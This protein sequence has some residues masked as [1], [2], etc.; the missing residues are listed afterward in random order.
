LR[1]RI[2]GTGNAAQ[3]VVRNPFSCFFCHLLK[4]VAPWADEVHD[5][6]YGVGSFYQHCPHIRIHAADIKRWPWIVAPATFREVDALTYLRELPTENRQRR[7]VVVDPPYPTHPAGNSHRYEWLYYPRPWP[8]AYLTAVLQEARAKARAV[9]L[10]Y[11]GDRR[12]EA[13]FTAVADYVVIWRFVKAYLLVNSGNV[14][15]RNASKIFIFL[16]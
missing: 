4:T 6:T 12:E 16:S 1:W 2:S 3:A 5:V 10:K 13:E 15:V 11:M 7:V 9:V 14:V 8:F